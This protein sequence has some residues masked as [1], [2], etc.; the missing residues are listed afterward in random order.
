MCWGCRLLQAIHKSVLKSEENLL[1]SPVVQ[2]LHVLSE[3]HSSG[4]LNGMKS[5][6]GTVICYTCYLWPAGNSVLKAYCSLLLMT[7]PGVTSLPRSVLLACIS[8]FPSTWE[9]LLTSCKIP[10]YHSSYKT[11]HL[12]PRN[13]ILKFILCLLCFECGFTLEHEKCV[14]PIPPC[15]VPGLNLMSSCFSNKITIFCWLSF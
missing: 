11:S 8:D 1:Y 9:A 4:T 5:I 2:L 6:C 12:L 7:L 3:L 10:E 15:S 13:Q 14:T